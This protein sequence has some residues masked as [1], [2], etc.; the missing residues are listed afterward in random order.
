MLQEYQRL[1]FTTMLRA[2]EDG[3]LCIMECLDKTTN[4]VVAVVCAAGYD[5]VN[6]EVAITPFAVMADDGY[7]RFSPPNPDGG[8]CQEEDDNG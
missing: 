5:P 1:N 7:E 2:A 3:N 8:F 6:G 4:E